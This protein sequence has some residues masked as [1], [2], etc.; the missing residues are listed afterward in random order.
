VRDS[1][2]VAGEDKKP[3]IERKRPYIEHL[4]TGSLS[5]V[6][7]SAA[8]KTHNARSTVTDLHLEGAWPAFNA[9]PHAT[10]WYYDEISRI[11]T[12]RLPES[13]TAYLLDQVVTQLFA[14]VDGA[15]RSVVALAE[16]PDCECV[17]P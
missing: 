5:A 13:R 12:E 15:A 7:I 16:P 1:I 3:W 4:A 14:T 8:D 6:R 10:V 2:A 9:C 17:T 11:V